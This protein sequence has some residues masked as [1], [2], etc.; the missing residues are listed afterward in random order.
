MVHPGGL[1]PEYWYCPPAFQ[2]LIVQ[3]L[4]NLSLI[5]CARVIIRGSMNHIDESPNFP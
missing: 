4:P 1:N 5:N 3:G 2:L